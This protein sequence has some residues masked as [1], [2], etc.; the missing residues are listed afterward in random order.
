MKGFDRVSLYNRQYWFRL[1]DTMQTD[2]YKLIGVI[3]LFRFNRLTVKYLSSHPPD[4]PFLADLDQSF[5]AFL[6]EHFHE[7]NRDCAIEA[8]RYDKAFSHAFD[9][10]NP[11]PPAEGLDPLSLRWSLAPHATPLWLHWNFRVFD[12]P[13]DDGESPRQTLL[14]E[15]LVHGLLI[16]RHEHTLYEKTLARGAFQLLQEF[17]QPKTLEEAFGNLE[18][19]TTQEEWAEI[20]A[21]VSQWFKE[22]TALGWLT[23]AQE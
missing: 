3:G 13:E 6:E 5:P 1:I 14:P 2:A 12:P 16:Y 20:E 21:G 23:P 19:N 18:D 7:E 11:V 8:A 22:F 15:P 17:Q 4:S 10:P 9:A